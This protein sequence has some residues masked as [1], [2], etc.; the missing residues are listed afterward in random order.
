MGG[1][2]AKQVW[3][4]ILFSEP[5]TLEL[6][7]SLRTSEFLRVVVKGDE[8]APISTLS[9][10]RYGSWLSLPES[11]ARGSSTVKCL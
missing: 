11:G 5:M 6:S 4:P 8:A 3:Q 9:G 10:R 7:L 1:M 2:G